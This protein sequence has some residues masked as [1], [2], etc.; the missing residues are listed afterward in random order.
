MIR[1]DWVRN[2]QV[3]YDRGRSDRVRNNRVRTDQVSSVRVRNDQVRNDRELVYTLGIIYF[4]R[5]LSNDVT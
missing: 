2:N 4:K 5:F 1:L 3:R